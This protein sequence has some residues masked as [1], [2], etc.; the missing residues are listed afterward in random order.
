MKTQ[1]SRAALRRYVTHR[2]VDPHPTPGIPDGRL[3]VHTVVLDAPNHWARHR[4]ELLK[5]LT[6]IHFIEHD[7]E[8]PRA[9]CGVP[10]RVIY[11]VEFDL[12]DED[13]CPECK[14]LALTR[15]ITLGEY[16]RQRQ[17]RERL[18]EWRRLEPRN[19]E[20]AMS[21]RRA[22]DTVGTGLAML[23]RGAGLN[24]PS[25]SEGPGL[26]GA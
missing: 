21:L 15:S 5:R 17:L 16:Q 6:G 18:R 13:A 7:W 23:R 26:Q 25:T 1:N 24:D 11:P 12:D 8:A 22:R 3:P 14:T 9:L 2:S 4:M 10:V 19:L 20:E